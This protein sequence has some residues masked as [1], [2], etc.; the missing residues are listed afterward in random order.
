[1]REEVLYAEN[2]VTNQTNGQNLDYVS[3]SLN[4]GE[5][6]GISG[7]NGDGLSSLSDVLT[8]VLKPVSGSIY[9][10]GEKVSLESPEKARQMEIYEIKDSLSVVPYMTVAENMNVLCPHSWRKFFINPHKNLETARNVFEYYGLQCDPDSPAQKLTYAQRTELS[11]CRALLC[12]AKILICQEAGEGFT[13]PELEEFS[14][15]L[16]KICQNGISVI[17]INS[18][19]RMA[20]RFSQRVAVMRSGMICYLREVKEAEVDE[21]YCYMSPQINSPAAVKKA[22]VQSRGNHFQLHGLSTLQNKEQYISTQL[23]G[24]KAVGLIWNSRDAEDLVYQ[25]FSGKVPVTGAVTEGG[26]KMDFTDWRKQN[27]KSIYCLKKRFWKDALYHNMTVAENIAMRTYHRFDHRG[28]ILKK[29]MLRLALEEFA[30]AHQ[31]DPSCLDY[32]PRHLN[33]EMRNQI[34]LWGML[35]TPP[36]LLVLDS[37]CFAIDEQTRQ[38]LINSLEELKTDR[39][40]V[41]WSNNDGMI[42]Y[43]YCDHVITIGNTQ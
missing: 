18:D 24:G 8:G 9:L 7:L 36:K 41:F 4:T 27:A 37:P 40:A 39:T 5:V 35:F 30:D 33:I 32:Y 31:I 28:G 13:E 16:K 29:P 20:L 15:F 22:D 38:N 19:A 34:V 43:N 23:Y 42:L 2:L 26:R 14:R 11:I 21:M 1:M 3:F 6:L 17:L 10:N 25:M 12:G